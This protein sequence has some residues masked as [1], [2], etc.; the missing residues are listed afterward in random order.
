MPTGLSNATGLSATGASLI[1]S[2]RGTSS[3]TGLTT[4]GGTGGGSGARK[5]FNFMTGTL[6]FGATLTRASV[7]W[8][9]NSANTLTSAAA[10]VARFDYG[11]VSNQLRGLLVEPTQT[12]YVRNS[13]ASGAVAGTPGTPPVS[14]VTSPSGVTVTIVG[15]FTVNGIQVLRTRFFGTPSSGVSS[16]GYEWAGGV[17]GMTVGTQYMQGAYVALNVT[18]TNGFTVNHWGQILDNLGGINSDS[19]AG[20]APTSTL[21]FFGNPQTVPA[22]GPAPYSMPNASIIFYQGTGAMDFTIDIG[23]P[24]I[25]VGS[26]TNMSPIISTG[27][28]LTRA[29]DVLTLTPPL[30]TYNVAIVRVSGTINLPGTVVGAAG[31]VVPTDPSPLQSITFT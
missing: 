27:T 4:G 11:L 28:A 13:S 26:L 22:I 15:L 25:Q 7:G 6:P 31:Y 1:L 9:F 24:V 14:W 17:T 12:N 8:Y 16:V 2:A 3:G 23:A 19:Q 20:F 21:T 30:G 18:T 29:A 10:N 5:S